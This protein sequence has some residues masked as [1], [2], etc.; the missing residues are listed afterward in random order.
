M[1]NSEQSFEFIMGSIT[2]GPLI[3]VF[4]VLWC[5]FSPPKWD[6]A[7]WLK[8]RNIRWAKDIERKRRRK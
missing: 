3:I 4:A 2:I 5:V 6:P 8:E 1:E 7:I